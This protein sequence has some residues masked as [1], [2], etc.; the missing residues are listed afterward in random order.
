MNREKEIAFCGLACCLCEEKTGCPGCRADG[1]PG[2]ESCRPL[3]CCRARGFA[4]C[5]ECPS[6]PCDAAV[7]QSARVRAFV[8]FIGRYGENQLLCALQNGERLG[9]RYH[10]PGSL[11]G[12]YDRAGTE[13]EILQLLERLAFQ[14]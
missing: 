2:S 7:L 4:G 3:H 8:R 12:D 10:V 6:F 14:A 5:W 9:L 13:E 11:E 1:C